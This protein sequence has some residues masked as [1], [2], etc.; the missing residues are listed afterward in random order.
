M[1]TRLRIAFRCYIASALVLTIFGIVYMSASEIMPYHQRVLGT[2]WEQLDPNLQ[3]LLLTFVH[4]TGASYLVGAFAMWFLL[5]IP[6]R[7]G[8]VWARW[9]TP[10]IGVGL[11]GPSLLY[12][13][14]LARATGER[15]PWQMTLVGL[16]VLAVGI[17]ASMERGGQTRSLP[18]H[19]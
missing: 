14:R 15:T 3:A 8:E 2:T 4:A 13:G 9:A 11:L 17:A 6:F 10:M 1:T 19:S 7:R 12:A 16:L 18:T 5:F